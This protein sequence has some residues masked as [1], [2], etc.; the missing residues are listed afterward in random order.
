M[1]KKIFFKYSFLTDF[2]SLTLYSWVVRGPQGWFKEDPMNSTQ[3][4]LVCSLE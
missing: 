2:C 1:I 3:R 4:I